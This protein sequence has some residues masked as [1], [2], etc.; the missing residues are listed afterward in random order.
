LAEE[1]LMRAFCG[2]GDRLVLISQGLDVVVSTPEQ[3]CV[4]WPEQKY[5]G[6]AGRKAPNWGC[7]W[8][9]QIVPNGGE[10]MYQSG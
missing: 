5:I 3:K 10:K 9:R 7:Q 8:R 4:G 1:V 2:L 6:D